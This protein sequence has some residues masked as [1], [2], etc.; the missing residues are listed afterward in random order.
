MIYG[1]ACPI[2]M[3]KERERESEREG[4]LIWVLGVQRIFFFFI[5]YSIR[6]IFLSLPKL[7]IGRFDICD[8]IFYFFHIF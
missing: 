7:E 6:L 1:S 8:V 4:V 5:K 3:H 2:T